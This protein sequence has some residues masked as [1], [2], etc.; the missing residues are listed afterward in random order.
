MPGFAMEKMWSFRTCLVKYPFLYGYLL[1]R[2]HGRP[3]DVPK[4]E[5]QKHRS[6]ERQ[7]SDVEEATRFRRF[8]CCSQPP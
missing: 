4:N 3:V 7:S 1:S 5:D 6:I 2:L 8:F